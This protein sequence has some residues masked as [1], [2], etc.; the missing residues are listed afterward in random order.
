MKDKVYINFCYI[1]L[2]KGYLY[3]TKTEEWDY[4]DFMD[5]HCR[6]CKIVMHISLK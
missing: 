4:I 6:G 5:G 2:K 1:L 3:T